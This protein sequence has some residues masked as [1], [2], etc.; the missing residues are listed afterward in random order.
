MGLSPSA[1]QSGDVAEAGLGG[2]ST[3]T[4]LSFFGV[5]S[6]GYPE[7]CTEV[8]P[9]LCG[10][11]GYWEAVWT[12][13]GSHAFLLFLGESFVLRPGDS[14]ASLLQRCLVQAGN[15]M[16]WG[17]PRVWNSL[18]MKSA[19]PSGFCRASPTPILPPSL[20]V[21]LTEPVLLEN[22]CLAADFNTHVPS[23]GSLRPYDNSMGKLT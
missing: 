11:Q 4:A 8:G 18:S 16:G 3:H 23:S 14:L 17:G 12:C 21:F 1:G 22:L 19:C 6:K 9:A 10:S 20:S 5:K 15:P 13:C 7:S 2:A